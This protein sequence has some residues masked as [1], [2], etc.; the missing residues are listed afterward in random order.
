MKRI[1][2]KNS[3]RFRA[4]VSKGSKFSQ[5]YVPKS[6]E[7]IGAGDLVEVRLVQKRVS[8]FS[9]HVKNLPVFKQKVLEGVIRIGLGCGVQNVFVVGSFL[10]DV[11]GYHDID[12]LV[13]VRDGENRSVW[14]ERVLDAIIEE[15]P[16]KFHVLALWESEFEHLRNSCPLTN[17]ML[18]RY[19][20]S[21][22][23]SK[24]SSRFID[25]NRILFLLMLPEDALGVIVESRT[26]YDCVRRVVTIERF[27]K[28]ESVDVLEVVKQV[29]NILGVKIFEFLKRNEQINDDIRNHVRSLLRERIESV[30]EL[31]KN[32]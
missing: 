3:I 8:L 6:V 17:S 14:S 13:L 9:R 20:S 23:I 26:L 19:V 22:G 27:L 5:I 30:K 29:E 2:K 7:E 32:G 4:R 21:R 1:D 16:L 28:K 25:K 12:V 24:T 10:T 15:F 11:A 18:Y 31:L